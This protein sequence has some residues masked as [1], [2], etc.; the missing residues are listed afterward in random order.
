V[1]LKEKVTQKKFNEGYLTRAQEFAAKK[2]EK[3]NSLK[4]T[5]IP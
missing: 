3:I 1:P 4:K 5:V 2:K